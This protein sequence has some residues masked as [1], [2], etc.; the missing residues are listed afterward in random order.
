MSSAQERAGLSKAA[1]SDPPV[2]AD[3]AGSPNK[4]FLGELHDKASAISALIEREYGGSITYADNF[5]RAQGL[6]TGV[7]RSA[8]DTAATWPWPPDASAD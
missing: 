7:A 5:S 8:E 6:I 2:G 4:T 1:T 3:T